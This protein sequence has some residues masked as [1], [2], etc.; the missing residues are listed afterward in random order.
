MR[1]FLRRLG[2]RYGIGLGLILVVAAT[3]VIAKLIPHTA[4]T[5]GVTISN[6]A[7]PSI[8]T[9]SPD[10]GLTSV[11]PPVPPST[12]PGAETPVSIANSFAAAWLDHDGVTAAAWNKAIVRF[13]TGQLAAQFTGVDPADVPASRIVGA[14]SLIDFSATYVQVSIPM[15]GGSLVLGLKGPEGLWLVDTVDWNRD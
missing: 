12:S 4:F 9:G 3:V 7:A 8:V 13:C 15:D 6:G 14:P 5:S 10:D 11:A 1:E 2:P